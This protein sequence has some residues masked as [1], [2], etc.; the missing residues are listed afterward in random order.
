MERW[1]SHPPRE[2]PHRGRPLSTPP[3]ELRTIGDHLRKRRLDLGLVQREVAAQIGVSTFTAT[4]WEVNRTVPAVR[5]L[6]GLIK[7]VGYVPFDVGET[8]PERI[9]AYRL[10]RGL[11]EK[12]LAKLLRV[13]ES[14]IWRWESG[15][16]KPVPRLRQRLKPILDAP[17]S[18]T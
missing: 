9:R 15:K 14:T 12:R 8:L 18:P 16:G 11:S 5:C 6:P 2:N 10:I 17:V 1:R 3:R 4:N 13:D 7:F